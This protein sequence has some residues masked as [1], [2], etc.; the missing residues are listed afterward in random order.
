M[1]TKNKPRAH[2]LLPSALLGGVAVLAIATAKPAAAPRPM[3]NF[4]TLHQESFATAPL[5][6]IDRFYAQL[7]D[8]TSPNAGVS[9]YQSFQSG[10]PMI[11][12][13]FAKGDSAAQ[14]AILEKTAAFLQTL[15]R[16]GSLPGRSV[17]GGTAEALEAQ[18]GSFARVGEAISKRTASFDGLPLPSSAAL[19]DYRSF[20]MMDGGLLTITSGNAQ[21]FGYLIA[22]LTRLAAAKPVPSPVA[23]R[24]RRALHI[25]HDFA[26]HDTL[27]F[28]WLEMPAWHWAGAYPNMRARSL[29]RLQGEPKLDKRLFFRAFIDYDLHMLATAADLTAAERA[30]PWL[31]V[32]TRDRAAVRDAYALGRRVLRERVD[33]RPD[34]RGFGFDRGYWRDNPVAAY[35]DCRQNTPPAAECRWDGYVTDVSHGQRWPLWLDSFAAAASDPKERAQIE[36][37]RAGLAYELAEH[38]LRFDAEHRP[39]MSNFLDGHDGWYLFAGTG[40]G[41]GVSGHRPSSLTGWAMRYAAYASLAPRDSR[42]AEAHRRFC[43]VIASAAPGDIAFRTVRYGPPGPDPTNGFTSVIDDYGADRSY[44]LNCRIAQALGYF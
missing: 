35:A 32:N 16:Y 30:A 6:P 39:I 43:A 25:V 20:P 34:G 18:G 24:W 40:T 44:T 38:V 17:F 10:Q 37:W 14:L 42:I 29:A 12:Y 19:N 7:I 4:Q 13:A 9:L 23:A 2:R 11:A 22:E 8:S 36:A 15:P 33:R 1:A 3:G 27:R 28:Y 26:A 31:I 21:Q 5:D 41:A